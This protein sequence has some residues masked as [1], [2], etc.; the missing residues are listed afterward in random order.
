F[1]S[2]ALEDRLLQW[3]TDA[4][5]DRGDRASLVNR[6][7]EALRRDVLGEGDETD[8]TGRILLLVGLDGPQGDGVAAEAT[9]RGFRIRR[10]SPDEVTPALL[11]ELLP[12]ALIVPAALAERLPKDLAAPVVVLADADRQ[13]NVVRISESRTGVL[14]VDADEP[15]TTLLD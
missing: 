12:R 4:T 2:A 11:G 15:P 3:A 7:A 6:F 9:L 10:A 8:G 14:T 13:S 5:A 1:R